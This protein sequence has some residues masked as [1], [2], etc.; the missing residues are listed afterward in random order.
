MH[1]S[2]FE[3]ILNTILCVCYPLIEEKTYANV[4]LFF[5]ERSQTRLKF[6]TTH[7]TAYILKRIFETTFN[8]KKKLEGQ[9]K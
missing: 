2:S 6:Q 8:L 9:N 1:N 7:N 5:S 3:S 4:R